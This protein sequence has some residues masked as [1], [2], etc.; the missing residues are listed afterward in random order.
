MLAKEMRLTLAIASL[1]LGLACLPGEAR[2]DVQTVNVV[3]VGGQGSNLFILFSS[4]VG[5]DQACPARRLVVAEGV[6]DAASESRFYAA[7][8]TAYA[9]GSQVT[10]SVSS[11]N[12]VFPA[13]T[14]L[15]WWFV[16]QAG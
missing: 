2:A 16:P 10:L 13:I 5:T 3:S 11:C 15:D 9:T 4:N 6:L 12:G 8:L 1:V 14:A 7:M